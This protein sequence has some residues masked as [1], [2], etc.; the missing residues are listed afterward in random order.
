LCWL[1][2]YAGLNI[3]EA[4]GLHSL[5]LNFLFGYKNFKVLLLENGAIEVPSPSH[6]SAFSV[7]GVRPQ[8]TRPSVLQSLPCEIVLDESCS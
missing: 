6:P 2:G 7:I 3:D 1:L 5:L 4:A 8:H